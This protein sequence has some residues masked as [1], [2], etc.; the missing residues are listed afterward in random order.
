M[1]RIMRDAAAAPL[2]VNNDR[3]LH[4]LAQNLLIRK[5]L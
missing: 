5:V 1:A 4:A 3:A 2:M